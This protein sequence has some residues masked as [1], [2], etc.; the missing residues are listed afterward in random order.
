[1]KIDG[2][3]ASP[4]GSVQAANR[5]NQFEKKTVSGNTISGGVDKVAVSNKAQIYQGLVDKV[6]SIEDI[7]DPVRINNLAQA[8]SDGTYSV[9]FREIASKLLGF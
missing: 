9:K 6:K 4:I 5:L 8:I 7:N 1:M 2:T 3:S